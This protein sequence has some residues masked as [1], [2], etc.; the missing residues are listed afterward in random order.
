[1]SG[2]IREPGHLLHNLSTVG[3]TPVVFVVREVWHPPTDVYE[4]EE[5]IRVCVEIAGMDRDE[6]DVS[7]ADG[8]LTVRG[9]RNSLVHGHTAVHRLEMH[10]GDFETTVSVPGRVAEAE[11]DA[12]YE[13]GVLCV[14]LPKERPR[15]VIVETTAA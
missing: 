9:H 15:R 1:M 3:S 4:T 12:V 2:R 6:F 13:N 10:Y 7:L 5:A 11:I 8:E 14:N